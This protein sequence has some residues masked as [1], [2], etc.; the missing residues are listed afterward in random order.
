MYVSF[1]TVLV[2]GNWMQYIQQLYSKTQADNTKILEWWKYCVA[3][4]NSI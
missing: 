1:S 2:C 4:I 3:T